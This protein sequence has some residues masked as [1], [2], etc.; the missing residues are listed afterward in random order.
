MKIQKINRTI[1]NWVSSVNCQITSLFQSFRNDGKIS[2]HDIIPCFSKAI[3]YFAWIVK[4]ILKL[5]E[6][7][8]VCYNW[9]PLGLHKLLDGADELKKTTPFLLWLILQFF[10]WGILSEYFKVKKMIIG[11][12]GT[13]WMRNN[14]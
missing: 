2:R 11:F 4:S 1:F 3:F 8:Q 9:Q 6:L 13:T 12:C 10:S 5:S 14:C 7:W